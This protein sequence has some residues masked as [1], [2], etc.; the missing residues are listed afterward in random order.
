MINVISFLVTYNMRNGLTAINIMDDT[1]ITHLNCKPCLLKAMLAVILSFSIIFSAHAAPWVD[2]GDHRLRHHIQLLADKNIIT[3]P[4]TTW[5]LM[6]SGVIH[7]VKQAD[8]S[9]LDEESLWSLRYVKHAFARQTEGALRFNGRLS[10]AES[11][12]AV[13]HFAD[14]RREQSEAKAS[15]DWMGDKFAVHIAGTYA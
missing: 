4:V 14:N 11:V 15:I 9:S 3:V 5:P 12:Q 10:T 7:D 1:N 2:G 13:K 8:Y 6:W